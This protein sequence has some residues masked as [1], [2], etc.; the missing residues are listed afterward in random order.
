VKPCTLFLSLLLILAPY[1]A[2]AEDVV[3]SRRVYATTGRSFQQL[4]VWSPV[5]GALEQL[6]YSSRDH[7]GPS[8][9]ADGREIEFSSGDLRLRFD[10]RT[11]LEAVFD[12]AS[13]TSR[14]VPQV[15]ANV[16]VPGCDDGTASRSHDGGRVAC[17]AHSEEI[18]VV[19]VRTGRELAH[20]PFDR[21]SA[22]GERYPP[23]SLQSTWS[24]DDARLLIATF[25]YGSTST[26]AFLDYFVLD[27]A[28]WRWTRAFSGN[29][30]A[31]LDDGR[32][33]VFTTPRELTRLP[34]TAK[35]VWTTRLAVFDR[36]TSSVTTLTSDL[37]NHTAL[38]LCATR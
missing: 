22:A 34:G 37:T 33:I 24:P 7:N 18:A 27:L 3:V 23:W 6:T 29:D 13:A 35:R 19:E 28:T 5:T 9:S 15:D 1:S 2:G 12:A 30:A 14:S 8:C 21:Q 10:R 4:W 17:A 20:V 31:W 25:G 26:S 11:G 32:R 38:T 36:A 16:A